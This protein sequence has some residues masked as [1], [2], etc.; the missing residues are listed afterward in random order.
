MLRYWLREAAEVADSCHSAIVCFRLHRVAAVVCKQNI[1]CCNWEIDAVL[2]LDICC[3]NGCCGA[4]IWVF[5]SL[6]LRGEAILWQSW[7]LRHRLQGQSLRSAG[8]I[9][10]PSVGVVFCLRTLHLLPLQVLVIAPKL[11]LPRISESEIREDNQDCST[12]KFF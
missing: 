5:S 10:T 3:Y 4:G 8:G 6:A 1:F 2:G 11:F 7:D 12:I 9:S